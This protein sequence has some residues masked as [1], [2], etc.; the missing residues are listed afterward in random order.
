MKRLDAA[1]D[2]QPEKLLALTRE[3]WQPRLGRDLGDEDVRQSAKVSS[4]L[5]DKP[6][7]ALTR[8]LAT[9]SR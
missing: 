8:P 1:N 6:A 5:L 7:E 9:L 4:R 2:S 3:V